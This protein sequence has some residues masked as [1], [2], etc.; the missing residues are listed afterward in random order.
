MGP[1]GGDCPSLGRV[2]QD[3]RPDVGV[4]GGSGFYSFVEDVRHL[5]VDTPYGPPSDPVAVGRVGGREVAFLPRH[6]QDHRFPPHRIP[7]RANLWALRSLGVRQVVAPCAVGSLDAGLGP[8]E[9]VV[10]D[11]LIDGTYGR[12]GTY[13]DSGA[14]H[15]AF[16]DPYCPRLRD[17]VLSAASDSGWTPRDGGAMVVING[18]RFSTRAESR[19]YSSTG[20]TLINM[21]GQPEAGLARELAMCYSSVALVT[22]RDAGVEAGDGVSQAEVFEIFARHTE[23]LKSLLA[24]VVESLPSERTCPC[25]HAL[26]GIDLPYELP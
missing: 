15:V 11:Q 10:P 25:R 4:I 19:Y 14:A 20:A 6:G 9:L 1:S 17:A 22:D 24:S 3:L 26:D 13:V 18:P 12:E 21:T 16:S 7:Y 8:G 23:A 2:N 5:T